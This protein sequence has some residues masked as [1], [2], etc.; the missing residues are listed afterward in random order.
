[1]ETGDTELLGLE[2]IVICGA[3][4]SLVLVKWLR[5]RPEAWCRCGE[6]QAIQTKTTGRARRHK[7]DGWMDGR[8]SLKPVHPKCCSRRRRGEKSLLVD[9]RQDLGEGTAISGES[10]TFC[11]ETG[12]RKVSYFSWRTGS[13]TEVKLDGF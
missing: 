13:N 1:M 6:H 9:N 3:A 11:Y 4:E 12:T 2:G 10:A 5:W 7:M 8:H